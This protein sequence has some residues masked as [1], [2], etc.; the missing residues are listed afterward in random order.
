MKAILEIV[1]LNVT[2][3]VTTSDCLE[4]STTPSLCSDD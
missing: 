1:K 2:D 3:V 4:D